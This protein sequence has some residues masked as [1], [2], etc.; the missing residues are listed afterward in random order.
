MDITRILCR[1]IHQKAIMRAWNF[2]KCSS[3]SIG[4]AA[5]EA[6]SALVPRLSASDGASRLIRV[7][8]YSADVNKGFRLCATSTG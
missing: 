2:S 5:G 3:W 7:E 8:V 4:F 1:I 6:K